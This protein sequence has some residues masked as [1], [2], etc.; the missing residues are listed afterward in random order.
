MMMN[1]NKFMLDMKGKV[2]IRYVLKV[3]FMMKM[4]KNLMMK[5]WWRSAPWTGWA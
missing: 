3:P 1:L 4:M 5:T 2:K